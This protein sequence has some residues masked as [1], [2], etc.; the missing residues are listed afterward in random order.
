MGL[1]VDGILNTGYLH[2]VIAVSFKMSDR[3]KNVLCPLPSD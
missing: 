3:P 1:G 2:Y